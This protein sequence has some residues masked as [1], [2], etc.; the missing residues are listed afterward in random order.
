MVRVVVVLAGCG[1]ALIAYLRAAG[2]ARAAPATWRQAAFAAGIVAVAGGIML[3]DTAFSRHVVGHLLLAVG[4]PT[5]IALGSPLAVASSASRR[6]RRALAAGRRHRLARTATHPLVVWLLFNGGLVALYLTPLYRWSLGSTVLHEVVHAHML[7]TG[8]L[9][10]ELAVG[11]GPPL[12]SRPGYPARVA[13]V[14]FSLPVHALLGLAVLSLP[15]PTLQ[16]AGMAGALADQRTGGWLLWV[17]GDLI[18]SNLLVGVLLAWAADE[19]RRERVTVV[20][21]FAPSRLGIATTMSETPLRD[22][23]IAR[24]EPTEDDENL[25]IGGDGPSDTGDQPTEDRPT[26]NDENLDTGGEGPRDTGDASSESGPVR[27][28]L[29]EPP[30][31]GGEDYRLAEDGPGPAGNEPGLR[32]AD[33]G[34]IET[35]DAYLDNLDGSGG[36]PDL[37]NPVDPTQA[38]R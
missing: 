17:A 2:R 6:V 22:S 37:I 27:R 30:P 1:G 11:S 26:E 20:A 3:P 16:P 9:F 14:G 38:R 24:D 13:A 34:D 31:S 32:G 36:G 18:V 23:D 19:E 12:P 28:S 10:A 7:A 21:G 25:D 4:G 29:A 15:R 5:L 8:L 33:P 35:D